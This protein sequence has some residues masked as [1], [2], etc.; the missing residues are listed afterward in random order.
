MKISIVL[1][2]LFLAI[3]VF[4]GATSSI[5]IFTAGSLHALLMLFAGLVML[6]LAASLVMHCVFIFSIPEKKVHLG[7]AALIFGTL[8]IVIPLFQKWE[9]YGHHR[10]FLNS[11][12]PEY[13]AAVDIILRDPS[14][15]TNQQRLQV[16]VGLPTGCSYVHGEIKPD[17]LVAIYFSGADHW[18]AGY[19]YFSGG[20]TNFGDYHYLTNNWY[21]Y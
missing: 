4:L 20:Q 1:L 5:P 12:L 19:A 3:C 11:A 10:W 16:L 2:C 7:M 14:I 9:N 8:I 15:I 21:E 18:S 17:G 13:Q 6:F